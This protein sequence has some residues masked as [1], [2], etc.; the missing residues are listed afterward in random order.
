MIDIRRKMDWINRLLGEKRLVANELAK[1]TQDRDDPEK[2]NNVHASSEMVTDRTMR[3]DYGKTHGKDISI[4]EF[5]IL[6][7]SWIIYFWKCL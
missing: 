2:G 6:I 5:I 4:S 7:F 3:L 1:N